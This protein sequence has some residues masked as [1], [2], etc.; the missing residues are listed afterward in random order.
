MTER[1]RGA[2]DDE[3]AGKTVIWF[4]RDQAVIVDHG[5]D[6]TDV[7]EHLDR[8][9]AESTASFELRTIGQ[10]VDRDRLAV[11]GPGAARLGFERAYVALTHR[12]DR[13]VDI[14]PT[15]PSSRP[16]R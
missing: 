1:Q 2:S 10:I 15:T 16:G 6:G 4:D 7:V 3:A 8:S 11:S 14:E 5:T 12:P 13:L 9:P